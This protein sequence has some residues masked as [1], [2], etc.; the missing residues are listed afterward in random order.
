M[1]RE[2]KILRAIYGAKDNLKVALE[3]L[4]VL[5]KEGMLDFHDMKTVENI[6]KFLEE[7]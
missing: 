5:E 1:K 6:K 4:E 3:H 2:D 7:K